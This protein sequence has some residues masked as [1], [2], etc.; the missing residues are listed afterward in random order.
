MLPA[1]AE[2]AADPFVGTVIANKYRI[3]KLLGEGGMGCVYVAE[4]QLGTS[5]RKVA[6]KTLHKHLST[7]PQVKAR[8]TREVGTIAQLE[9]P[10]TIQVFD[11]GAMEDGTLYIVME[12][13]QG[14]SVQEILEKD[15]PIS[16][17]RVENILRQVTGSLEEAHGHGI[18]HRDLKPDNVVLCERAGQKDWVEVL[19]FGIAKRADETDEKEAKL[20][21]QGMV[22]GTPPYM[23]PEQFSGAKLDARSDIYSLGIMTY[24]MLTG[25]LPFEAGTAWEWATQHM[26]AQPKPFEATPNGAL[27]PPKM[28]SAIMKALAKKREERWS[29]V[30]EFYEAFSTGAGAPVPLDASPMSMHGGTS[31]MQGGMSPN[32]G[33]I[34]GANMQP[35]SGAQ[36]QLGANGP[37]R[38]KTEIGTPMFAGGPPS[39][40]SGGMSPNHGGAPYGA[41]PSPYGA[42]AYGAPPALGAMGGANIPAGPGSFGAPIP[43][44]PPRETESGGNRGLLIGLAAVV[45]FLTIGGVAYSLS[46]GGDRKPV[47]V[48]NADPAAPPATDVAT[49]TTAIPA[50][51]GSAAADDSTKPLGPTHPNYVAPGNTHPSAHDAG[52]VPTTPTTPTNTTPTGIPTP[53]PPSSLPRTWRGSAPPHRWRACGTS[54]IRARKKRAKRAA[55]RSSEV[56]RR[57]SISARKMP[58]R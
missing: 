12:L 2:T 39:M 55:E 44:A 13:V 19:D 27:L 36:M 4:Q 49:T 21:Q 56:T 33:S 29:S 16:P 30:K 20:T 28:R 25:Q 6:V 18:I 1:E 32:A 35:V 7:D 11:F 31:A 10:N 23:S 54:P 5:V 52:H 48:V 38:A 14:K 50:D 45:A 41:A 46:R 9:H 57:G 42:P 26:T 51:P 22:L 24:E 37:V 34:S 40:D 17:P 47:P 15:G 58:S 53:K 8:F 3:V 43:I